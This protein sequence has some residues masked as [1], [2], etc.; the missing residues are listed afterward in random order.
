MGRQNSGSSN[1]S[2]SRNVHHSNRRVQSYRKQKFRLRESFGV[3]KY[4]NKLATSFLNVDGL[5]DASLAEV[6]S[7]ADQRSPDLIFLFET[8]RRLE[9]IGSDVNITG[10]DLAEIRRSD[11]AED[12]QGG[13]I[14][15][16]SKNTRGTVFK[17]Y[18]PPIEHTDLAYVDNE[19][20]WM[21]VETR[22]AKTAVCGVYFGCQF[23]DD[24]NQEWDEGMFWVLQQEILSL[25]SQGFR[26]LLVGDFNAH[27][28]NVAGVGIVGNNADINKNGERLL[29]FLMNHDLTHINGMLK[30]DGITRICSG[31]WSRQRG[32][33]RSI[34]D[35]AVLSSE[36]LNS[37]LSM[38]VDENGIYGGG[39][40]HNW[41]EI[42]LVDKISHLFKVDS[43]PERKK[44]WN[45]RDNQDW[46]PFKN[47]VSEILARK[48]IT[49]MNEEELAVLVA[50]VYNTAGASAI[51]Y[52]PHQDKR[53]S[54][55]K[56]LPAYIVQAL[57]LK[58]SLGQTWKSL[59]SSGVATPQDLLDAEAKYTDQA[60]V[61]SG[62]F[63]CYN[64][65]NRASWKSKNS[66]S[67]H[68]LKDFWSAVTGKVVQP[69]IIRTVLSNDGVLKTD[70]N[71]ISREIEKHLCST[72]KGSME[73]IPA[74]T[75][76]DPPVPDHNYATAP[77][78]P[79]TN[80]D[81][82]YS[83]KQPPHLPNAENSS[84]IHLNPSNWLAKDFSIEEVKAIAAKLANGKAKGWDNIP[85]EF[86]KNSPPVMFEVLTKLF[87]KVKNSGNFPAGWNCGR[88][89]LIHKKG[90]R[91]KLGNYRPLTVIVALSGFYSKLLNE[92]L[93]EVVETFSL[94]GEVQ[95]GFRKNRD[96]SDNLFVL[97]T[98]L[99]KARALGEKIHLGFVAITKAY[100]CVDRT[101][102]WAKLE[103]LGIN[104][105]F[106]NT[107]KAMYTGDSV[108]C[109]VNG[110]TTSSVFLRRGLRQGCSLSPLLF[111]LY[112]MDI[113][114]EL[115][116]SQE[117]L[118][119]GDICVSGLL[120]ANDI[121]L[122]SRSVDGLKNLFKLV[123]AHCD[124]L[125]LEINTNEGKTEVSPTNTVW[126]IFGSD[127]ALE[128]SLRQV[129]EY[130]YLGL[131][132]S[133][134]ILRTMQSKQGKC[135][136]TAKKY[137]F[138]CLH[139][140]RSGPDVDDVAL[141][142]WNQVAIPSILYG[143]ESIIF[144]ESTIQGLERIQS[145]IGKNILGLSL[146]TV[147][148][149]AQTEL[150]ILPFRFTLYR[151]QLRF[152][153][154]VLSLPN[155]RWAKKA[156]LEHLSL[157]WQSP[158]L[159]NIISIR[160]KVNLPFVPPS[161]RYLGSHLIQWALSET[162]HRIAQLKL[163]NVGTLSSFSRQPYAF[164][165]EH[166]TTIAQFR[167]SSAG[168]GNKYPRFA[169][170]L[171]ERQKYCPLC[172]GTLLTE[173]HVIFFCPSTEHH[174]RTFNLHFY[175]TACALK[176]LDQEGTLREYLND[177]NWSKDKHRSEC[178][179]L[180]H[181]LDTLR[182]HWLALW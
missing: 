182:G 80:F 136:K 178:L 130:S 51:G 94:L 114:E 59:S 42:T 157:A 66:K 123:K 99:W 168:L 158:Y 149:S 26:I 43:R 8:K 147:N 58:K 63:Q 19:R 14:A 29:E 33:S 167:L 93:I 53:S 155:H 69:S 131:E 181:A 54:I 44:V 88:I 79:N 98:I 86:I 156:L 179:S 163:P 137:K 27:I 24:R 5:S 105:V 2:T 122:I 109:T 146:K 52:K 28:G 70:P 148:I 38:F 74:S 30:P 87:N 115:S 133:S 48:D 60:N 165:H 84:D 67:K 166:L 41:S 62:L 108:R 172:P 103:R 4:Q 61:V 71:D 113:G 25:R 132:T 102:L 56:S 20:L 47:A 22:Y 34:I 143:C 1:R 50:S 135:L 141:A 176:G 160:E 73:P 6:S 39:S 49:N 65:S 81:H 40:D 107:L 100:D 125:V 23:S 144:T 75:V 91:A 18:N 162:N 55:R 117:G 169:G 9:E 90:I 153:F 12:K 92:R 154:R 77:P 78:G 118:F 10:Y 104:G 152:Y 126:E 110:V 35:F 15:C 170:V 128:L 11:T 97:N 175:R 161:P 37:V 120:F 45:I 139:I 95:N 64:S 32:T 151:A 164:E 124:K 159:Q 138:A 134:S 140:G 180:G 106:L 89:S 3:N 82:P 85:P 13:G 142:S 112:I 171:Y 116:T 177:Y 7:Y 36:H 173:A 101:I 46:T 145:E 72:F 76:P 150:G 16:Y 129:V 127:G 121:V 96:S 111:A 17:P 57:Q 31:L 21:T 83:T 119:L 174:R 68:N